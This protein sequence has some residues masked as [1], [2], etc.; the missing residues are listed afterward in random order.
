M[1]VVR[2]SVPNIDATQVAGDYAEF[3]LMCLWGIQHRAPINHQGFDLES[4]QLGK[5]QVKSRRLSVT[6]CNHLYVKRLPEKEF[7]QLAIVL[8]DREWLVEEARLLSHQEALDNYD[9]YC[10]ASGRWRFRVKKTGKWHGSGKHLP[11]R[12]LQTG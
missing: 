11:L 3:L 2:S 1:G 5:I 4:P 6:H 12:E 10:K 8:F 7:E 9:Y